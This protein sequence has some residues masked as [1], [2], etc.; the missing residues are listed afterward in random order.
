MK[1]GIDARLWAESGLGRYIRNLV[2]QLV[3]LDSENEYVVFGLAKDRDAIEEI[4]G[5]DGKWRLVV[6]D[7]RWYGFAEQIKLPWI[8]YREQVDLMHFPHFNIPLLYFGKFIVTI[9]DLTHFE[10]AMKRAT[11][12]QPFIYG[13]KQLAHK[14]VFYSALSRSVKIICVSRYVQNQL[15]MNFSFTNK[16]SEV[17]YEASDD[18]YFV[19]TIEDVSTAPGPYFFYV[20]NAHPHKNIEFL[21]RSFAE[22]RK[23]N[24]DYYLVLSGKSNFFWDQVNY[25]ATRENLLE[26]VIFT[27]YVDD[28]QLANLYSKAVAFVFPSLSEGFG[29]P[30]LEAMSYSCPVLSSHATCLPEIGGDAV[31]YFDPRDEQSLV[32][33]MNAISND[34]ALRNEMIGR[35]LAHKGKFSWERLGKQTLEIYKSDY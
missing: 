26:H 15:A 23:N 10:F 22:F 16:K 35:G 27:G 31:L 29:L 24:L 2:K 11:T 9:H 5:K 19:Q 8:L 3:L 34:A 20:G 14:L 6:A 13:I 18:T 32:T 28:S 21:L 33:H 12:L 1:I 30:L 17:T 25:Y 7:I 4:V